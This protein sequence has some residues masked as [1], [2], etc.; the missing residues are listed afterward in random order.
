MRIIITGASKGS[1]L[2]NHVRRRF[3]KTGFSPIYTGSEYDLTKE[4]NADALM[5]DLNPQTVVHMAAKCGG[6]L[7]NKNSPAEFIRDNV[8]INTNIVDACHRHNVEYLLTLGSVC[9]Y[10][11]YCPVPFNEDDIFNGKSEETNHPYGESKK[12]MLTTQNA[13][14]DQYG[15]KSC[16]I[17]PVNM[18]GEW[19][20]FDLV[21]SHVIPALINKFIN[22]KENDLS[23]VPI[24]GTGEATREFL[25]AGDCAE[26]I[27]KAIMTGLDTPKPINIGTGKDIS[28]KDLA[29]L[30]RKLT[31]YE[32][33]ITFTGEVSDGQPERRLD[34][35]RA[36]K[37][38]GFTAKIGLRE[39]LKKTIKWYLENKNGNN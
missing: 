31:K 20:H 26:A 13:Y 3:Q 36:K 2:G 18:L 33:E 35:S 28:I 29:Y 11:K 4:S 30:I 24:W 9:M 34:V 27:I 38:L 23:E 1:F 14:R 17:I 15:M 10:P 8:R 6:I 22:A 37:L 16:M 21:N 7:A 32:G 19:D 12:L 25:Y 5:R 39:G